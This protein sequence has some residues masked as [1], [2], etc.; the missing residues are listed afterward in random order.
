MSLFQGLFAG[1]VVSCSESRA[2]DDEFEWQAKPP[3]IS[4]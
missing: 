4:C 2:G 1:F 3:S